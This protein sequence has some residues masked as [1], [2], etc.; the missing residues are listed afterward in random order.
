MSYSTHTRHEKS[1]QNLYLKPKSCEQL[2]FSCLRTGGSS[3]LLVYLAGN[4][5]V[6]KNDYSYYQLFAFFLITTLLSDVILAVFC[7][8]YVPTP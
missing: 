6:P 8:F 1:V 3:E 2:A 7:D 4:V 5:W